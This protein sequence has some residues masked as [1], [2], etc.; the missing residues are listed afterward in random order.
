M[1]LVRRGRFRKPLR[2][3]CDLDR[4]SEPGRVYF[5]V[6]V[7]WRRCWPGTPARTKSRAHPPPF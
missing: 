7:A 3:R 2:R 1:P 4:T 6:A 5:P